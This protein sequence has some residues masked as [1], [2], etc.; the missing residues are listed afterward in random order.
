MIRQMAKVALG[1]RS[2]GCV[3]G[4]ACNAG[5]SRHLGFSD[6]R[7]EVFEGRLAR[8]R[9]QLFGRLAVKGMAQFGD[10][11]ILTRNPDAQSGRAVW[12]RKPATSACMTK[13]ASR[14]AGGSASRSRAWEAGAVRPLPTPDPHKS[15]YLQGDPSHSVAAGMDG[16]GA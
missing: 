3:V 10:E 4:I 6:S 2:P 5:I 8:V 11:A 7:F 12:A 15:P 9:I 16:R 14:T 1:R 13:N